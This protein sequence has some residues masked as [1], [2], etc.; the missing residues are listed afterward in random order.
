MVIYDN[1]YEDKLKI[2]EDDRNK[3]GIYR[4]INK[5]NGNTYIG[6]SVN[7]SVRMYTYHSLRSLAKS[8]RLIYRVLLK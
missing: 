4:G 6:S 8:N 5:T 3:I 2:L 7:I 1:A